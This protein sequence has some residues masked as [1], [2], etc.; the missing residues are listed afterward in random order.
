MTTADVPPI[1]LLISSYLMVVNE[2]SQKKHNDALNPE[3][4]ATPYSHGQPRTA[5]QTCP[6]TTSAA[7]RIGP[8]PSAWPPA[9]FCSSKLNPISTSCCRDDRSRSFLAWG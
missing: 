7:A 8:P 2:Q 9:R 5:A 3:T 1:Y 6:G 4:S